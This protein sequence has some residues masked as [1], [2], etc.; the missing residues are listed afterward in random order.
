MVVAIKTLLMCISCTT[1]NS[2]RDHVSVSV[3]VG[4]GLDGFHTAR[5]IHL[6]DGKLPMNIN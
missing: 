2:N 6:M 4:V 1:N 5:P 3:S